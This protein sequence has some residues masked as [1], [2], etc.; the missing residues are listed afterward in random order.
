[1]SGAMSSATGP[2]VDARNSASA[3]LCGHVALAA[4][5][6]ADA[7]QP[8]PALQL[9]A[10]IECPQSGCSSEAAVVC[11]VDDGRAS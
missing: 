9:L 8:T 5:H 4:S 2:L 6:V 7:T 10:G 3:D 11:P 1:M